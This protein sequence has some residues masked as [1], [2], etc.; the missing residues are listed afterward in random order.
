MVSSSS[1]STSTVAAASSFGDAPTEPLP[2]AV[3][4]E[5][6]VPAAPLPARIDDSTMTPVIVTTRTCRFPTMIRSVARTHRK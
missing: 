1:P 3:E 2:S 4:A 5:A 6:A